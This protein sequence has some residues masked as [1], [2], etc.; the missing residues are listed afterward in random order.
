MVKNYFANLPDQ[1]SRNFREMLDQVGGRWGGNTAI[2]EKEGA[3]YRT[4]THNEFRRDID[5]MAGWLLSNGF[6]KGDLVGILSENRYEWCVAWLGVV[7]AGMIVVPFDILSGEESLAALVRFCPIKGLCLSA[8]QAPKWEHFRTE[9]K[10]LTTVLAFDSL[11]GPGVVPFSDILAWSGTLTLTAADIDPEDTASI[12]FTSGTT[13]IP[14]GVMLSHIGILKNINASIM[15]LPIS[16]RDNFV[17]VL[18]FHHTYPTTCSFL[19]PVSVGGRVTIVDKMVGPSIIAHIKDNGGT[20]IIG[21][22]LLFDKLARGMQ[23][24]FRD[25]KGAAGVLVRSLLGIS[26]FASRK[27][28]WRLGRSLLNGIR[29]KAGLGTIRLLVA[30]GGP[31]SPVTATFFDALGFNIVQGY[32]MSENGPLIATS[33]IRHNNYRAVGL[34]VKLTDI[35]LLDTNA[36][37]IGEITVK[38]PSLMKGYYNNPEATTAVFTPDGY[39]KTGD[40]GRFDRDG[41]LYI[42]G[43]S[44]NLIVSPAGKNIYPEEIESR[45]T[46]SEVIGDILVL[47][48]PVSEENKGEEVCALCRPDYEKLETVY[49]RDRLT[50]E[51]LTTL[52]RQEV[53][54]VNRSLEPH[55]RILHAVLHAGE[56]EK[57]SSQKIKRFVYKV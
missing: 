22:P 43:R 31:L 18:P 17:A 20:I 39:L 44:K 4:W 37:G 34:P 25:M 9:A 1:T 48:K 12:I 35:R 23:A 27:L 55:K 24:K 2:I 30:G 6:R 42:T 57:T 47:G 5:R 21:V 54:R 32:G 50:E 49:G 19:S 26:R 45:F 56:F 15:S 28:K 51:F 13:G 53:D 16:E 33:T 46:G 3:G 11:T 29:K 40:L 52:I 14:K 10:T 41:F 38:S 7:S 8:Q 36:E